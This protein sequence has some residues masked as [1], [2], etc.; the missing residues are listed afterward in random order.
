MEHFRSF[1]LNQ[2]IIDELKDAWQL[3]WDE[4]PQVSIGQAQAMLFCEVTA[5]RRQ[6]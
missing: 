3:V 2:K 6:S 5:S 1:S 4:L